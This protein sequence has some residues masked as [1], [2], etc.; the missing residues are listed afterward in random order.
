MSS[1]DSNGHDDEKE[2]ATAACAAP[3]RAES[4]VIS[5]QDR[6]NFPPLFSVSPFLC[7]NGT[8]FVRCDW[9]GSL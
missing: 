9:S 5:V 4:S 7:T 3:E 2:R 6:E 1:S 8:L